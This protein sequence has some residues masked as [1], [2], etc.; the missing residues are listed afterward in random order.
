MKSLTVT[1]WQR[2]LDLVKTWELASFWV[3][4]MDHQ[5]TILQSYIHSSGKDVPPPFAVAVGLTERTEAPKVGTSETTGTTVRV[6][7]CDF[8]YYR[9]N[10]LLLR[11]NQLI[12][13]EIKLRYISNS[14]SFPIAQFYHTYGFENARETFSVKITAT[15]NHPEAYGGVPSSTPCV[16]DDAM[17]VVLLDER[18]LLQ[19]LHNIYMEEDVIKLKLRC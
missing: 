19:A 4:R 11:V 17:S 6:S 16:L 15:A 3:I 14:L 5:A 18:R 8:V 10:G 13:L 2:R 12:A 1:L 7:K 9:R